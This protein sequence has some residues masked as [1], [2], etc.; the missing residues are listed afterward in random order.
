MS[1][2][3]TDPQ[4][5]DQGVTVFNNGSTEIDVT[6]KDDVTVDCS[7]GVNVHANG[8]GSTKLTTDDVTVTTTDQHASGI[9]A[10][11]GNYNNQ[12][13]A[14]GTPDI[15]IKTGAVTVN[16]APA[17]PEESSNAQGITTTAFIEGN[18]DLQTGDIN[19]TG[20]SMVNG[21]NAGIGMGAESGTPE[22]SIQTGSVIAK[23][24]GNDK[25]ATGIR[26]EARYDGTINVKSEDVEVA[27]TGGERSFIAGVNITASNNGTANVTTEKINVT[28]KYNVTGI[29]IDA[30]GA[31]GPGPGPGGQQGGGG[32]PSGAAASGSPKASIQAGDV[33]VAST[34]ETRNTTGI[35]ENVAANGS[36]II[37]ANNLSVTG[38]ANRVIGE[39]IRGAGSKAVETSNISVN[40]TGESSSA[41]G[42][43][44]ENNISDG[45]AGSTAIK[46]GDIAISSKGAARGVTLGNMFNDSGSGTYSV[47][48]GDLTVTSTAAAIDPSSG[49]MGMDTTVNGV[50]IYA[51]NGGT[52]NMKTGNIL[53]N[54]NNSVTGINAT[55]GNAESAANI[56]NIETKDITAVGER[57]IGINATGEVLEDG[58]EATSEINII[59]DGTVSGGEVAILVQGESSQP[60]LVPDGQ[61][62]YT[63]TGQIRTITYDTEN[64]NLTMWAA[65]ENENGEIVRVVKM[66]MTG[67]NPGPAIDKDA[68]AAIE[69]RINY[70]VKVKDGVAPKIAITTAKGNTVVIGNNKYNT[71]NETEE[72]TLNITLAEDEVLE[73]IYYNSDDASTLTAADKLIRNSNGG[74]VLNMMRGGGMLLGLKIHKHTPG[75]AVQ[76]NVTATGYDTVVY[77]ST[78]GAEMSRSHTT[79]T[80]E[81]DPVVPDPDPVIPEPDPVIP[82]PV[83]PDSDPVVPVAPAV[84][85]AAPAMALQYVAVD[86]NTEVHGV[87]VA[88]QQS[89]EEVFAIVGEHLDDENATVTITG[90]DQVLDASEMRRFEELKASDRLMVV[91]TV[92]GASDVMQASVGNM[93]DEAKALAADIEARIANMTDEERAEFNRLIRELFEVKIENIDG[94]DREV[95]S[96]ELTVETDGQAAKEKYSFYN[97]NDTWKLYKIETEQYVAVN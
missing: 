56:I 27:G 19:V 78:C 68:S 95:I 12:P 79:I 13:A 90:I 87:K 54:G 73:G 18:I 2:T 5:H 91:L 69:S 65:N 16:A 44:A 75:A 10:S 97:D 55:V 32:A 34:G 46:A 63:P 9:E 64:I 62:G 23:T 85:G 1:G 77:C 84:Q 70:I 25:S 28:G 53:V 38:S 48:L 8:D 43:Q 60:V 96:V 22:I 83:I 35:S 80:P 59:S 11:I 50:D 72:V 66:D 47:E 42:I 4:Q 71:A 20:N 3:P 41:I 88:D 33:T 74:Y 76:E 36:A 51:S 81:P 29:M 57:G 58:K 30:G 31:P 17:N 86:E 82:D 52:V 15:T 93:S 89:I 6:V 26:T 14:T 94:E 39:D 45:K 7:G 24:T 92:I 67:E 21:I 37:K 49:P 40:A 61:G